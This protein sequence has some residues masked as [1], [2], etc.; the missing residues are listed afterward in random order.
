[1]S[2][3]R[4]RHLRAELIAGT[5]RPGAP[6]F[7][8]L[9]ESANRYG[10]RCP[11]C[12]SIAVATAGRDASHLHECLPY[13]GVCPIHRVPYRLVHPCSTYEALCVTE[14]PNRARQ[15]SLT[16]GT[17]SWE[18]ARNG[19]ELDIRERTIQLLTER[20]YLN[21]ESNKLSV[22]KLC[23][24]FSKMY[25]DGFED[26]RLTEIAKGAETAQRICRALRRKDGAAVHPVLL[27]LM[28]W[29]LEESQGYQV[30]ITAAKVKH[31]VEKVT[32]SIRNAKRNEWRVFRLANPELSRT[33]L[34]RK[35][36][37]LWTWL[38]RND[39]EWLCRNLP[40]PL[41]SCGKRMSEA[42]PP[43]ILDVLGK[44]CMASSGRDDEPP[45]KRS[46]YQLRMRLGLSESIFNQLR[47]SPSKVDWMDAEVRSREELVHE[48]IAWA[49]RKLRRQEE[50]VSNN[51][52]AR[53]AK[54]RRKTVAD[55][56][57]AHAE[58]AKNK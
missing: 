29:F 51:S 37:L 38:H 28:H 11:E 31:R 48:R 18:L 35:K 30:A 24:D 13:V 22:D 21:R 26:C 33:S 9:L 39:N 15:N 44:A 7:P 25:S 52:I 34:H 27:V 55:F 6:R 56:I 19:V 2:E 40:K 54:L 16:F 8:G 10:L 58:L 41:V 43:A 53:I 20:G 14:G 3:E 47:G 45:P 57:A 5:C 36:Y 49:I 12:Q 46:A 42:L 1:M 50:L 23:L 4:R 17:R 32:Q